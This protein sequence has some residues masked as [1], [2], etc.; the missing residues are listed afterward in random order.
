MDSFLGKKAI[1]HINMTAI[2]VIIPTYNGRSKIEGLLTS[3]EAQTVMDFETI[4]VVDGSTDETLPFLS[5]R[6]FFLKDVKI[7]SQVNKGRAG[8]RN[9]GALQ[10]KGDILI[11]FDDDLVVSPDT[12]ARYAEQHRIGNAEAYGGYLLPLQ[13]KAK[14]EFFLFCSYLNEKWNRDIALDISPESIKT[15]NLTAASLCVSRNIFEKME[16][17]NENLTDNEDQEF[18]RRLVA[19][20][21]RISLD[22]LQVA[23]HPI[24]DSFRDFIVRLR[25]YE[26]ARL[27][28]SEITTNSRLKHILRSLLA[29]PL[30]LKAMENGVLKWLPGWIRFRVYDFIV[31]A[32]SVYFPERPLS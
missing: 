28:S 29:R 7:I 8:A 1:A 11:F 12:I 22:K 23:Y 27:G 30:L 31:T 18:G 32:Y 3:L 25:E 24:Q 15:L 5:R 9:A 26:A 13:G 4:I 19:N 6:H 2:S 20:G 21:Y 16:G 10:A 17:F 14:V